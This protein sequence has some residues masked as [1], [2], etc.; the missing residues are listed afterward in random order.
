MHSL[1]FFLWSLIMSLKKTRACWLNMLQR[2]EN[3]WHSEY[4]AYG[5]RGITICD[6]WHSFDAFLADMGCKPDGM[7]L[8]RRDNDK[9]YSPQNC[10]WATPS[11]QQLNRRMPS[12]N[13]TKVKGVLKVGN[14]WLARGTF[15]GKQT[16][17]YWGR[18][19]NDAVQARQDWEQGTMQELLKDK[20]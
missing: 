4:P 17:L 15:Q 10:R 12:H 2:C 6:E 3:Q 7:S 14:N 13:K 1:P 20:S 19:Y 16:L 8:D 5:G 11:Q 9:G 18:S